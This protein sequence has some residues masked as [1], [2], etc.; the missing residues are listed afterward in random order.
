MFPVVRQCLFRYFLVAFLIIFAI[1]M[2]LGFTM[3][4]T[5]EEKVFINEP[6]VFKE[7]DHHKLGSADALQENIAHPII[8]WWTKFTGEQFNVLKCKNV[9]CVF[10]EDRHYKYHPNTKVFMFYGTDFTPNDLPLPRKPHHEWALLHEESPKNNY[11]FSHKPIMTL[12]NHT[13]TFRRESDY[14]ISTQHLPTLEWLQD[15]TYLL[16]TS[17]KTRYQSELAPILYVHS[18][19]DTPSDRD[20]YVK[21]LQKYMKID[22]YGSCLHNKDLPKHLVDPINGMSHKDFYKLIAKYKFAFSMENGICDDYMTEKL[23]RPLMV[24]TVPVILGS[25]KV[26]DFLPH[27][28]SAIIIDDFDT[29]ESLAK[30][31]LYLNRNDEE[32]EKYLQ[33]KKTG[34]TNKYLKDL[35]AHREWD[36]SDEEVMHDSG[37]SYIEGFQCFV[38]QRVHENMR[39]E[40]EGKMP[41]V[42]QATL[43]HYGCPAP[44]QFNAQSQ[45]VDSDKWK[46][47]WQHHK[48]IAEKLRH[49]ID[50]GNNFTWKDA[51]IFLQN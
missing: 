29:A 20:T 11:L 34:I 42:Y 7:V 4:I 3:L 51:H 31:L 21:Y 40:K 32:Y 17:E 30:Y 43:E 18:D 26:R 25:S 15:T 9:T 47:E 22:S 45:R 44:I 8:V 49:S 28:K 12:F 39:L 46:Y 13:C 38:C 6:M 14:P 33:W 48:M 24:G 5:G 16:P 27:E 2:I 19:C 41:K 23:W 10:T 35:M 50:N 1:I 36:T 37:I